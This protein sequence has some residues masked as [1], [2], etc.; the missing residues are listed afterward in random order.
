MKMLGAN[1]SYMAGQIFCQ[2]F[3]LCLFGMIIAL[4][5]FYPLVESVTFLA[6]E[7]TI[8]SSLQQFLVV[9][10]IGGVISVV[11]AL[12]SLH[13]LRKIYPLEVYYEPG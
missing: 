9:F 7:I 12:I 13:R 1:G 2:S 4:I 8:I 10:F 6:P 5:L 3:M 11:S